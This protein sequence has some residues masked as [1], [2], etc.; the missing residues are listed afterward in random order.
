MTWV[1]EVV[2]TLIISTGL[3]GV[4]MVITEPIKWY[5]NRNKKSTSNIGGIDM[6]RGMVQKGAAQAV[7]KQEEPKEEIMPDMEVGVP[8]HVVQVLMVQPGLFQ[9]TVQFEQADKEQFELKIGHCNVVQ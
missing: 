3:L 9:A 2:G 5:M 4:V 7:Q 8:G 6:V 1:E